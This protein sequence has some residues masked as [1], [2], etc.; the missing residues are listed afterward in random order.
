MLT[1][2]L[3][4]FDAESCLLEK[5]IFILND[6][7]L[8]ISSLSSYSVLI[9][10]SQTM[11]NKDEEKHSPENIDS[12]R[13]QWL[14]WKNEDQI[15]PNYLAALKKGNINNNNNN[16]PKS[17]IIEL[18]SKIMTCLL[19]WFHNWNFI[20]VQYLICETQILKCR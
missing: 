9:I 14:R 3:S 11:I 17:T 8:L 5:S 16:R 1:D 6:L 7:N 10:H 12:F 19:R 15:R 2:N 4:E 13:L 20:R 18:I